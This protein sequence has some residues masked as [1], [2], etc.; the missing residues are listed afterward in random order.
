MT[1]DK[2]NNKGF[3]LIELIVSIAVASIILTMLIQM[4]VMS[5]EARN[6][7][8]L[9]SRLETEAHLLAEEIRWNI[10]NHQTQYTE[11]ETD[12]TSGD[13]TITFIYLEKP[14][15]GV[16]GTISYEPSGVPDDVLLFDVSE[17]AI[18]YNGVKMH[19]SNVYFDSSTTFEITPIDPLCNPTTAGGCKDVVLTLNLFISIYVNGV[20][21]DI[22]EFE[23][24]III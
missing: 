20:L 7:T 16:G 22:E 4:L 14:V 13:I 2:A 17:N 9:N 8:Y 6:M 21:V 24:T 23:T 11:I 10:F 18:F 5:V 12:G 3:T 19:S 1:N 15:V